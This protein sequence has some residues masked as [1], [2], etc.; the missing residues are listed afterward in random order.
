MHPTDPLSDTP[1]RDPHPTHTHTTQ[2]GKKEGECDFPCRSSRGVFVPIEPYPST[3]EVAALC[4]RR[5]REWERQRLKVPPSVVGA[6]ESLGPVTQP[7]PNGI[8]FAVDNGP[9][10]EEGRDGLRRR[11][12]YTAVIALP[13]LRSQG[14]NSI[15]EQ[16]E[17][18]CD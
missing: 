11:R 9:E 16:K 8:V 5:D 7:I 4:Y 13:S 14:Y 6:N 17:G 2:G 12:V 15:R 10:K 1:L 3:E 18:H